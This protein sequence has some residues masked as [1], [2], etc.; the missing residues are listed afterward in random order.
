MNRFFDTLLLSVTRKENFFMLLP[1]LHGI[2]D[3]D[4]VLGAKRYS[5]SA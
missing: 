5:K 1:S 3:P 4:V 2:T